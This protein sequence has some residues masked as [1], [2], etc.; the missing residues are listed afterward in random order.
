MLLDGRFI[1]NTLDF[2]DANHMARMFRQY[3][4]YT[5]W[6]AS[7]AQADLTLAAEVPREV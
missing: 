7:P 6:L 3:F 2:S 4:S 1:S 5:N